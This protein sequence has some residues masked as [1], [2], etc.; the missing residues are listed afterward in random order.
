MMMVGSKKPSK[1][2][3]RGRTRPKRWRTCNFGTLKISDHSWTLLL[4]QFLLKILNAPVT[5]VK[6]Y[7]KSH[8]VAVLEVQLL[9]VDQSVDLLGYTPYISGQSRLKH[10]L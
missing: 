10:E 8:C 3:V 5:Y 1:R 7:G 6:L 9:V 2:H 4:A